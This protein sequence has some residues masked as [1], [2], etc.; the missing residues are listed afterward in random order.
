VAAEL[1]HRRLERGARAQGTAE[2]EE[3][4]A[5]A[6]ELRAGGG[7]LQGERRVEERLDLPLVQVLEADQVLDRRFG[8]H[9][10]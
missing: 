6:G 8:A 10:S 3:A 1:V 5:L 9:E 7:P 2:E 4:D